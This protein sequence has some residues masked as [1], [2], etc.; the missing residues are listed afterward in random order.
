[1][2]P[3]DDELTYYFGAPV[4]GQLVSTNYRNGDFRYRPNTNFNGDDSFFF[5]VTDGELSSE[6]RTFSISVIPVNDAPKAKNIPDQNLPAGEEFSSFDLDDYVEDPDDGNHALSWTHSSSDALDVSINESTHSVTITKPTPDW[7]GSERIIFTVTDSGNLSDSD[8]ALFSVDQPSPVIDLNESHL[9]FTATERSSNPAEKTLNI[10]N[11]GGRS[12]IWQ[13][14]KNQPWLL[15]SPTYGYD[16]DSIAIA[17]DIDSLT[18]QTYTDVI[19]ITSEE[20]V[21]SPQTVSVELEV[22]QNQSPEVRDTA[23]TCLEDSSVIIQLLG[24]DNEGDAL[25]FALID[26]P[27]FGD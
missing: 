5:W 24:F 9:V 18:A 6:E 15:L 16:G 27:R 10:T 3:D 26:L 19:T 1:M 17:V 22:A 25:T 23:I 11:S 20:A 2:D 7:S 14:T 12:F 13:A 8:D 21:N 4:S